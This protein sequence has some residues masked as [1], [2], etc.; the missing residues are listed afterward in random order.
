MFF[1]CNCLPNLDLSNFKTDKLTSTSS[2]F[3]GCSNLKTIIVGEG[4]NTNAIQ[5]G[6]YI[7]EDCNNLIGGKG[8]EYIGD[9][10]EY[11]HID[12]GEDNPGYFT[13]VPI[14][15]SITNL[16]SKY[17][18]VEGQAFTSD[19][20]VLTVVCKNNDTYS[21]SLSNAKI[22]GFDNTKIGEQT[23]TVSYHGLET[24]FKVKVEAKSPTS[25]A[26]KS[27]PT[28]REYIEGTDFST[29][30]GV[31]SVL[32]NNDTSEDIALNHSNIKLYG[33]DNTKIGE[34]TLT[35]SYLGLETTFN[36]K[37]VAKSPTSIAIKSLPTKRE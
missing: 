27:L 4:W 31:V 7:F 20:G 9:G 37:V 34:Q 33:F 28:K 23:L 1:G 16:P 36:V 29:E 32:Y 5:S 14:L 25:I 2:M 3:S 17:E 21:T 15:I 8:T 26:I 11:A 35:A 19:G 22:T 24:T 18:Y 6:G 10:I 30:G 13:S 12:G